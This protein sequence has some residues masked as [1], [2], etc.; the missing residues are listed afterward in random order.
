MERVN[1]ENLWM[2]IYDADKRILRSALCGMDSIHCA[3]I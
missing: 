2:P 3:Q 1:R